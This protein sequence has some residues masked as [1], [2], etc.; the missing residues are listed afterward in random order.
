MVRSLWTA[1]SGMIGQQASIDT[2]SNNLANVNTTGYKRMRADFED[3]IYQ[4]VRVAGTPATEDTVVPVPIQMGHGVKLAATQHQFTQGNLQNTENISDIAIA[5][6]GFFR[7]LMYDG[8]FGYT[9]DGAFKIDANGQIVTSNGYK[10]MPEVI[11]PENFIPETLSISQD[12][13]ITVKIPGVD[14]AIDVGQLELYRFPNPVGLSSIG[15]NLFKLSNASGEPIPGRPGFDGMGKTIH[16]FLE[17]SNVAVVREMVAMIVA[18]RAY[19]FNSKAI[20]TSDNMLATATNL[21][22]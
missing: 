9:R 12:G 17:M 1:A 16:K 13:R 4:T 8:S 3:L 21:K 6:D 20:Q 11:L 18:Q 14:D 22:R 5:G 2:I 15:E 10:L 7:I 19:E